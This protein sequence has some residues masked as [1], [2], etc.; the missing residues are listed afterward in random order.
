[1]AI[2]A[3][4]QL[5]LCSDGLTDSLSDAEI[6]SL[7]AGSSPRKDAQRLIHCALE[8]GGHDNISVIVVYL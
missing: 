5:L 1:M 8:K 3:G 2:Q 4:D 7:I 6:S